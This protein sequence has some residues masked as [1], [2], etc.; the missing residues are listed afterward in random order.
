MP[1]SAQYNAL[2]VGVTAIS[3]SYFCHSMPLSFSA[4]FSF[5]CLFTVLVCQL[6]R[7]NSQCPALVSEFDVTASSARNFDISTWTA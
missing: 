6:P 4:L 1:D 3:A 7:V 5:C 2:F